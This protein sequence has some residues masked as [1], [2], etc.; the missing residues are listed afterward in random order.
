M[1][2]LKN[3]LVSITRNKSRNILIGIIILVISCTTAITL[4]IKNS[5]SELIDSYAAKYDVVA[6]IGIDRES[7]M[8]TF[9]PRN[10]QNSKDDMREKYSSISNLTIDEI[11]KYGESDY[12]K[13]Y[14]EDSFLSIDDGTSIY[15][16]I[17]VVT[18]DNSY[19]KENIE[20]IGTVGK[21]K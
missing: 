11:K 7:M 13:S 12:V 16:F 5:S 10:P 19:T 3:A 1:Y 8:R 4:A 14:G 2:I 9:D 17:R 20:T 6:S 21:R 18:G 15:H